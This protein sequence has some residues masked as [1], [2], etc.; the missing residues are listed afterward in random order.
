MDATDF[1]CVVP[2]SNDV[3]SVLQ[4]DDHLHLQSVYACDVSSQILKEAVKLT[5]P[6]SSDSLGLWQGYS[7]WEPLEVK[8]WEGGLERYNPDFVNID[9]VICTE[10]YVSL[11]VANAMSIEMRDCEADS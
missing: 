4:Q 3:V 6:A 2:L 8:I 1:S 11:H 7:R 9:C 5:A 10:V